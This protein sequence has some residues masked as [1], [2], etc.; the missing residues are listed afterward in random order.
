VNRHVDGRQRRE[1]TRATTTSTSTNILY[2]AANLRRTALIH[3][4]LSYR[5][6]QPRLFIVKMPSTTDTAGNTNS[7]KEE[8]KQLSSTAC[9]RIV[10]WG[11]TTG[12]LYLD[13]ACL[14]DP[15]S[16]GGI[17]EHVFGGGWWRG[18]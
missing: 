4:E 6:S 17:W 9:T 15:K 3:L 11:S 14:D 12:K 7:S 10:A 18:R 5:V 1:T 16:R 8:T 2:K 13:D